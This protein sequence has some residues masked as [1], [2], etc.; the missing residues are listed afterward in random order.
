[1]TINWF[2]PVPPARSAIADLTAAVLPAMSRRAKV[3]VWSS[4]PAWDRP[5]EAHAIFKHYTPE[6]P[7]WSEIN[8]ADMTVYQIGNQPI[9]H[10]PIWQISRRHPGIVMLHELKLQHF[11]TQLVQTERMS[12]LTYLGFLE[13][14]HPGLGPLLADS[15]RNGQTTLDDFDETCPL[16]GAAF[17][18]ALGVAAHTEAGYELIARDGRCPAAYVPLPHVS[19]TPWR[20][21]VAG[22]RKDGKYRLILFGFLGKNRHLAVLLKALH[23][24]PGRERFHLDI[25]GTLEKPEETKALVS[26]LEVDAT[27][28]GFVP[29]A[30]LDAALSESHLA[31]NLRYPSMGEASASQLR[32]WHHGLPS[33]VTRDGW[34][35]TLPEDI[36]AFVRKGEEENDIHKHL[37]GFL[38]DPAS[39]RE[40]GEN[41][42]K[43]VREHHTVE[44]YADAVMELAEA[45]IAFG[46]RWSACHLAERAGLAMRP[47]FTPGAEG[48]LLGR[49]S[50][51]I[52]AL[53]HR[54]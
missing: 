52:I 41:G 12:R 47:W 7:P 14:H 34:F 39:Y 21:V 37:A 36:V 50:R 9:F 3:V 51:E 1:M 13:R 33:L 42:R 5:L 48:L 54:S 23:Q 27:V 28:H 15:F 44:G 40:I 46:P 10:G 35:A 45:A 32:I 8:S 6:R 53:S 38:A 24:F 4:E 29:E 17:E 49:T 16:T 30:A 11:F 18:G 22:E 26:T 20:G 2:S 31:I 43:H 25:Y 19:P